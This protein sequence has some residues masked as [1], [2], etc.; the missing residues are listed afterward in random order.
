MNIFGTSNSETLIGTLFADRIYGLSGND[1]LV[2]GSGR[3][4]LDGGSGRDT[5]KGDS[6]NDTLFGGSDFGFESDLLIG[7]SDDDLIYGSGDIIFGQSGKDRIELVTGGNYALGGADNDTIYGANLYKADGSG[8]TPG[9]EFVNL[10]TNHIY[11]GSGSDWIIG[12]R[13][14]EYISGGSG[15]DFIIGNGSGL[16]ASPNAD[17]LHGGSGHDFIVGSDDWFEEIFGGTGNDYID[18]KGGA[19]SKTYG[20]TGNDTLIASASHFNELYGEGGNDVFYLSGRIGNTDGPATLDGGSGDDIFNITLSAGF[21]LWGG[22][23]DDIFRFIHSPGAAAFGSSHLATRIYDFEDGDLID[24]SEAR[25]A[26]GGSF[27]AEDLNW[28][29][30]AQG[31]TSVEFHSID[32]NGRI[33]TLIDLAGGRVLGVVSDSV[34]QIDDFI[35]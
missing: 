9:L 3:D 26:N 28:Y 17:T 34:L 5:L 1:S 2:G 27:G 20:G 22:E 18:S 31:P 14:L 24:L 10:A 33:T 12:G 25:D 21:A 30:I 11:G 29:R 6:G 4:R 35:F 7:G 16:S 15:N 19:H 8:I 32:G 13:S 23:D